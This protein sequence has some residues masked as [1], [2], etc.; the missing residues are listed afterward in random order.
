MKFFCLLFP[1]PSNT[2][3]KHPGFK[4]SNMP[5]IYKT[6]ISKNKHV[7]QCVKICHSTIFIFHKIKFPGKNSH[8]T[9]KEMM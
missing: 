7:N 3:Q 1:Y 9:L 2:Q 6:I 8:G 5:N 4:G